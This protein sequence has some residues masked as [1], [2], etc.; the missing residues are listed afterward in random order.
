MIELLS[1]RCPQ[2]LSTH[3]LYLPGVS[4]EANMKEESKNSCSYMWSLLSSK[5][6]AFSGAPPLG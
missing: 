6:L 1:C 3:I 4:G 2:L 5:L